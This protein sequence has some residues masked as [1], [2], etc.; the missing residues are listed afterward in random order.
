MMLSNQAYFRDS[1]AI[2]GKAWHWWVGELAETLKLLARIR[3]LNIIDFEVLQ[4]H[5]LALSNSNG[6]KNIRGRQNI[7]L[8]FNDNAILYRK[9]RLPATARKDIDKVVGYEFDKYFPMDADNAFMSCEVIEPDTGAESIEVE[10]R[11]IAKA[12]V[13]SHLRTLREQYAIE[14]KNLYLTNSN[15]EVLITADMS[16]SNRTNDD[17]KRVVSQRMLNVMIGSLLVA[18]FIYPLLK[19][20]W[21][22]SKLEQEVAALETEAQPIIEIREKIL[23]MEERFQYLIDKKKKNPDQAYLWSRVSR[24]IVDQAILKRMEINGRKVR[25]EGR[26]ASVE[27]MINSF[28]TDSEVS[29]VKIIGSVSTSED[30]QYENMKIS[31]TIDN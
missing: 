6:I 10:I 5:G 26:T 29:E 8:K 11:A 4:S 17:R 31:L 16:K 23:G 25:L 1:V 21:R 28:E 7:A 27:R 30:N 2:I 19:L 24:S 20:D 13:E 9:L 22:L 3:N 15:D 14:V 12:V 18:L